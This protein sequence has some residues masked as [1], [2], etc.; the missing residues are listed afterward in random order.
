[1][2]DKGHFSKTGYV[3]FRWSMDKLG[4]EKLKNKVFACHGMVHWSSNQTIQLSCLWWQLE[5][6]RMS[7]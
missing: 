2:E 5:D 4:T 6:Y 1:M 3:K 7:L